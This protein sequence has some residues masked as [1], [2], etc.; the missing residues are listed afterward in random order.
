MLSQLVDIRNVILNCASF[1]FLSMVSHLRPLFSIITTK[2]F[3]TQ[4]PKRLV[5]IRVN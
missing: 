3:K 1:L 4:L 2:K 5:T